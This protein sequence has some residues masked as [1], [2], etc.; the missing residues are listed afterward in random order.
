MK[1][2]IRNG[3]SSVILTFI[4]IEDRALKQSIRNDPPSVPKSN[5]YGMDILG[6]NSRH[7]FVRVSFCF[8][9]QACAYKELVKQSIN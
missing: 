1:R 7:T 5:Y 3:P 4:I 2:S 6:E 9:L 8:H